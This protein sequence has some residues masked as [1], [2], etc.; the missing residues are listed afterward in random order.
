MSVTTAV[1]PAAFMS[2]LVGVFWLSAALGSGVGGNALKA[3]G[4]NVP[5]PGLFLA[6]GGAAVAVAAGLLLV[7][8]PLTRRLGV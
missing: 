5:G 7:A 1:A 8:R 2:Q 6:L 4:G 3:A